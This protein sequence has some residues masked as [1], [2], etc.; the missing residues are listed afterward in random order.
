MT[1][2]GTFAGEIEAAATAAD[3]AANAAAETTVSEKTTPASGET[4]TTATVERASDGEK[5]KGWIPPDAHKRVVDGFH[6]RLDAVS[7]ASGLNRAEVEEAM[8]V[9]RQVRERQ[10]RGGEP[11]PDAKDEQGQFFY[12]P[13]QAAKW[14]K[15]QAE[16]I[17][18]ARLEEIDRRIAPIEEERTIGSIKSEIEDAKAWPGFNE[19]MDQII[20]LIQERNE[21]R[22]RDPRIP[23]MSL[24]EAYVR[25]GAHVKAASGIEEQITKRLAE[26]KK[27][28]AAELNETTERV[29]SDVKPNREPASSRKKDSEKSWRELLSEKEAEMR[30]RA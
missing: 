19:N 30:A 29:Q 13:Q 12:S 28:W 18:N 15:W 27:K 26:E 16:Q 10:A 25:S 11:Q 1:E 21:L 23:S 17:V 24:H 14:A 9:A 5:Y 22:Q 20:A 4:A 6:S 3:S 7:W 2:T 8:Q